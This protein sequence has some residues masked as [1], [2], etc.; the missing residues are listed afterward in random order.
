[1]IN[2]KIEWCHHT[3]N[4]WWGCSKVS[5]ACEHC[6]AELLT[7]LFGKGKAVW[8]P[9]GKRWIRENAMRDALK[10]IKLASKT[11][12]RQRVFV[13]SMSDTFEDHDG[14]A[15][16][17]AN[18][19]AF[20]AEHAE[21]DWLLLTKRPEN[22]ARMVP[23]EWL[24]RGTW[25]WENKWPAHIWIG[26]TVEDQKRA[27]E[28]VPHLLRL[29]AKV[30]FLSCEPLLGPL[31]FKKSWLICE[32]GCEGSEIF[33]D[34]PTGHW[35][36][37]FPYTDA[38]RP[39]CYCQK[40]GYA[41]KG[42]G[43]ISWVICGGESGAGARP[44]ELEWARSLRDQCTNTST[45]FFFKQWGEWMPEDEECIPAVMAK[46]RKKNSGRELDGEEWNEVPKVE[47]VA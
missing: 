8:G 22:V 27:E 38:A 47:V 21:V 41:L 44:M 24:E 28:R 17:R 15:E 13:N 40:C 30:R 25:S 2:S 33:T 45:K 32:R 3:L 34:N 14:L 23:P 19:L 10:I 12:E 16:A 6:Y 43:W 7:K 20:M 46:V 18:A 31:I 36:S 37:R 5:P 39:S 1:M 26:T 42:L 11:T 29:N 9:A 4:W 35:G